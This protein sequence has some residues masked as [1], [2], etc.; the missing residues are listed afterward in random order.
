MVHARC[1]IPN[2]K[3]SFV[4]S[5][6]RLDDVPEQTWAV[7]LPL[8]SLLFERFFHPTRLAQELKMHGV[9]KLVMPQPIEAIFFE[10]FDPT[11]GHDHALMLGQSFATLWVSF[12]LANTPTTRVV[13]WIQ[14]DGD[15]IHMIG[16][17]AA[18]KRVL[19]PQTGQTPRF[20][21]ILRTLSR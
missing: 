5:S 18:S 13:L 17:F 20:V 8:L 11:H 10:H 9:L 6:E 7:E 16:D 14:I 15:A 4:Q 19:V 2:L 1:A 12:P 3:I 21:G